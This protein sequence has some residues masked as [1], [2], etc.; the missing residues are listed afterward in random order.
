MWGG[1]A[2]GQP[3][4]RATL[5]PVAGRRGSSGRSATGDPRGSTREGRPSVRVAQ[6]V[7]GC[8]AEP[9][10]GVHGGARGER[11]TVDPA[12]RG[13]TGEPGGCRG[14]ER[15][16]RSGRTGTGQA[17]TGATREAGTVTQGGS[18]VLMG[19]GA[20]PRARGATEETGTGYARVCSAGRWPRGSPPVG[21]MEGG[22][23]AVRPR[24]GTGGRP[25][26]WG[27]GTRGSPVRGPT[28]G[29]PRGAGG[30]RGR[31]RAGEP[32]ISPGGR[33]HAY[34]PSRGATRGSPAGRGPRRVWPLLG[35]RRDRGAEGQGGRVTGH[36]VYRAGGPR[37][38][39]WA[40]E[41]GKP[42]EPGGTQERWGECGGARWGRR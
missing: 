14:G 19:H 33:R 22:N 26:C 3:G 4:G 8:T 29:K 24:R 5:E 20:P 27:G 28:R 34:N 1:G 32:R 41:H 7:W 42:P 2:T 13:G 10:T 16:V 9:G 25:A 38:S 30:A 39:P 36:G 17:V 18:R 35:H 37:A 6:E 12:R 21:V 11:D 31:A 15:R 40:G 23:M